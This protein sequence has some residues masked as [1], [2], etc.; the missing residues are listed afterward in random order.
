MRFVNEAGTCYLVEEDQRVALTAEELRLFR[1]MTPLGRKIAL[2][3][4]AVQR[5]AADPGDPEAHA[6]FRM[7]R[8]PAREWSFSVP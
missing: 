4:R 8:L 5:M 6:I 1:Q 3:H 7:F 2:R